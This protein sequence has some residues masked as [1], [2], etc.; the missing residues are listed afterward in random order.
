MGSIKN[1]VTNLLNHLPDNCSLEDIQYHLYILEKI[2][3]GK[4]R[5]DAEGSIEH[6]EVERRIKE[7]LSK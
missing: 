5:S 4:E 7:W 3:K 1:D 6:I 2:Q